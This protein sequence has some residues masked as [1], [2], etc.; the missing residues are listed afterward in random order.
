MAETVRKSESD[1]TVKELMT[2]VLDAKT[3]G[4]TVTTEEEKIG[5]NQVP[6]CTINF[7]NV[8]ASD[9]NILSLKC[10][11]YDVN[12]K[13]VQNSRIQSATII[14]VQIRNFLKVLIEYAVN[15][16]YGDEKML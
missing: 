15:S 2:F 8:L 10:G 12:Q 13:L 7:N 14:S 3:P 5:C 16:Y 6:F 1:K 9:A 4:I 11:D